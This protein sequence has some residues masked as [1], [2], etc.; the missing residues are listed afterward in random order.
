LLAFTS[1]YFFESGLFNGLQP[2][3]IKKIFPVF[4]LSSGRPKTLDLPPRGPRGLNSAQKKNLTHIF[5]F[6]N[7][8]HSWLEVPGAHPYGSYS[9]FSSWPG[10]MKPEGSGEARRRGV[11]AIKARRDFRLRPP[12][13]ESI[14]GG[15]EKQRAWP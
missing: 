3:Q 9:H 12:L 1:V 15:L 4:R 2:I 14:W 5:A 8:L 10:L 6:G 7:D 13:A 11:S